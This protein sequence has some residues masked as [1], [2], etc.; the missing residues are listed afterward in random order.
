LKKST[1]I[2]LTLASTLVVGA[3]ACSEKGP[4]QQVR[5]WCDPDNEQVCTDRPRTGFVP[6]FI[7]I[8]HG[9]YYYDQRGVART[10]PGGAIARGAPRSSVTRGGFGRT[11]SGRSIGA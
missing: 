8:Y 5:A 2:R 1:A 11:G 9:G 3:S 10:G 6:M 4:E 7:P